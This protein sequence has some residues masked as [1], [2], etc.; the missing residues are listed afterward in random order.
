LFWKCNNKTETSES[1]VTEGESDADGK[2]NQNNDEDTDEE[3]ESERR[4]V[5]FLMHGLLDC[6]VTW[7][8]NTPAKSLAF[9]L[10]DAGFDVW[11]GNSRGNRFSRRHKT[12]SSASAAFWLFNR[13]SLVEDIRA[14]I[15]YVLDYTGW[16]HLSYVGHSQG[17]NVCFALLSTQEE[18]KKKI[19]I[20]IALA[21]AVFVEHQKSK[22]MTYL[23]GMQTDRIFQSLGMK[24]FLATGDGFLGGKVPDIVVRSPKASQVIT[25]L[26]F[27]A[28]AGWNP[29]D[30]FSPDR[31]PLLAAHQ[32]G[33]TSV[34]VMAHWAQAIRSGKFCKYDY[35]TKKN[36]EIYGQE[37]PPEYQF[38]TLD[39]ANIAV[40]YGGSDKLTCPEDVE[41]MI[42]K[43]P[44]AKCVQFEPDYAHLDFVWGDDAHIRI[45]PRIVELVCEYHEKREKELEAEAEQEKEK[46]KKKKK[47]HHKSSKDSV[48][49]EEEEEK[50]KEKD[51]EKEKEKEKEREKRK[52]KKKKKANQTDKNQDK[53][54]DNEDTETDE[55]EGGKGE[56]K[57][58]KAEK[59]GHKR[60]QQKH[61]ASGEKKAKSNEHHHHHHHQKSPHK[62][63]TA[64]KDG[65]E[66]D[67]GKEK[68][69]E[70]E[71]EQKDKEKEQEQD[72]EKEKNKDNEKTHHR[73]KHHEKENKNKEQHEKENQNKEEN[74]K[75]KEK[76]KTKKDDE[77]EEETEESKPKEKKKSKGKKTQKGKQGFNRQDL[78]SSVDPVHYEHQCGEFFEAMSTIEP[79]HPVEINDA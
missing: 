6:S 67:K 24:A 11:M 41:N 78:L 8:M 45:Y 54:S 53:K 2:A 79:N 49:N 5:V 55:E 25:K 47:K 20:F 51:K 28:M 26:I 44:E 7:M 3:E 34:M 59:D 33:G 70:K 31:F 18:F 40:F 48:E 72:R 32:P 37:E 38:S 64:K 65:D 29:N 22:M 35:G 77:S 10:V 58:R 57:E 75:E 4:P 16:S 12:L 56:G 46:K 73:K 19:D 42:N 27:N 30:N 74:E 43:L 66:E 68:A 76:K 23:S 1:E 14:S 60:Q 62:E 13:D 17:T 63:K 61:E 36:R 71:K 9:I 15:D 50:G 39:G 52:E 69:E 21:P